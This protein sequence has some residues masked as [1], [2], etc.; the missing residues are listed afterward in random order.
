MALPNYTNLITMDWAFQGQPFVNVPLKATIVLNTLDWAF[1]GQPF[2]GNEYG[3]ITS[4]LMA[5]GII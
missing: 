1:Q 2:A 5:A 3:G 4:K